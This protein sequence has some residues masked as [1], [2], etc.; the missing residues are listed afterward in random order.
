MRL[1]TDGIYPVATIAIAGARLRR[2]RGRPRLRP[3]RR[4]PGRA[5]AGL[6]ASIPARRTVVA[7][8]EGLGWVAQIALFILLGLLVF[9]STLDD[10]ALKGLALSAALIF[11][12]RPLAD[13]RRD[14]ASRRSTCASG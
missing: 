12:A 13:L 4:L 3:A 5:G 2:R 8:H 6:G 7:F 11:V 14:R 9:P 1:P 10:V